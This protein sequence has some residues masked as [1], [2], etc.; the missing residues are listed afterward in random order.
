MLRIRV[1]RRLLGLVQRMPTRVAP[2]LVMS[3]LAVVCLLVGM[4]AVGLQVV[5]GLND[6]TQKLIQFQRKIAAFRQ[7]QHDTTS[8]LLSVSSALLL[9]D[10]RTMEN[11]VRQLDQ[12]GYDLD[13]VAFVAREEAGLLEGL[14]ADHRR[15]SELVTGAIALVRDGHREAARELERS[16]LQPVAERLE[17][18]ASEM[19]N[20]AESDVLDAT[21]AS[22]HAYELSRLI[23]V[24]FV[25]AGVVLALILGYAAS[26]SVVGPVI[27]RLLHAIMPASAVA[28]LEAA[29]RVIPRR[30]DNVAVFYADSVGFTA[31]CDTHPPEQAV[32]NL[33]LLVEAVED[34]AARHGLEK[35]KTVGDAIIA[36]GNLLSP[37]AD[38]VM[39]CMRLAFDLAAAA[40]SNPAGWQVRA[41]IH[42]GSVVAGIIGQSN[43]SYDLWGDTVNVAARLATLGGADILVSAE[44]WSVL[45]GRCRGESLG[46]M[47]LKGKGPT[48]V[49]RCLQP[50]EVAD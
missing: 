13:R 24:G 5:S 48:V 28:E 6:A 30:F 10:A 22:E 16:Q 33:Q 32:A 12:F 25:V 50:R 17:R 31:Y 40:R 4:G 46:P 44:A 41:G 9:E 27:D 11:A 14:Q 42:Y 26:W 49:Y 23:V 43:F 38:P 34:L 36:T 8:A 29:G 18:L 45:A 15:F 39:A 37:H 35:I 47:P 19:V 2:K 20:K 21:Q 7:V 3:L 1:G